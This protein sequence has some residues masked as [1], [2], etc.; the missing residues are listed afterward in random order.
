[1]N[2]EEHSYTQE[3][4]LHLVIWLYIYSYI[5]KYSGNIYFSLIDVKLMFVEIGS[6]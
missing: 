3:L 6:S 1:M 5:W 2:L 4:N